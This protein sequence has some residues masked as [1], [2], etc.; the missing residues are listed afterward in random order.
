[1]NTNLDVMK[2]LELYGLK[3]FLFLSIIVII[4]YLVKS[5]WFGKCLS[6]VSDKFV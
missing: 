5:E 1:M 4:G 3:G 2:F 6:K